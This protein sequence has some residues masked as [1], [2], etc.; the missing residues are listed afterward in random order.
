MLYAKSKADCKAGRRNR[1]DS[2]SRAYDYD[3]Y[4][5]N[6]ASSLY[7]ELTGG[8]TSHDCEDYKRG[9][10]ALLLI[11]SGCYDQCD[12]PL[13]AEVEETETEIILGNYF[14]CRKDTPT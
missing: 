14:N 7:S 9:S 5:Y 1:L 4:D 10:H 3:S 12:F 8:S 11:C 13:L 2:I 6:L